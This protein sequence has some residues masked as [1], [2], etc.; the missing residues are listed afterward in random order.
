MIQRCRNRFSIRMMCRL[1]RVAP[2]GYYA[3][4]RRG[5]SSRAK[6]NVQLVQEIHAIYT[7]HDGVYGSPKIWQELQTRGQPCGQH[8]VARLMKQEGLQGIPSRKR[9]RRRKSGDRPQDVTNHLARDFTAAQPNAI[10]V[11]DITNIRTAEGWLYLAVVPD[12][13]SQQVIGWAMK[14]TL[15]KEIVLDALLIGRVGTQPPA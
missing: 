14:P 15:A 7:E 2:S 5:L 12:L 4:Q 13:F 3:N 1:L 10:W 6:A 8:R 11:T 9:W